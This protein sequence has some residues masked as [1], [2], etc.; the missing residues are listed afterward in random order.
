MKRSENL[1]FAATCG[2]GV[3]AMLAEEIAA[4][5]GQNP[6]RGQGVVS[7]CGPL[8]S[9]YM[10][11]LWSRLASRV[12]LELRTFNFDDGESL[13]REVGEI[14]WADHL[15]L[16]TTFAVDCTVTGD[17]V[18]AIHSR[19]AA[20][21]VKDAIVD[22]FRQ[23]SGRR[24]SVDPVQPGVRLHL[25]V[26]REHATLS[27]DLSGDSLHR[28]GYRVESSIAPLK[29]NLAAA[30]IQASGWL[31]PTGAATTL[32]DP[33][34]GS[35][36]L[37]IEAALAYGDSAPGLFRK[38]FGFLAW[39]GHD[40]SLWQELV[41]EALARETEG[42][43]RKEWPLLVGYDSDPQA[44]RAAR[45]NVKRAGL[46]DRIRI[47]RAELAEL[48]REE[49][50]GCIVTNLPFGERLSA[51][52]EV[53]WL[54]RALGRVARQRFVGWRLA[55]FLSNPV[56]TDSF[57]LKWQ[58]KVRLY[59]GPLQCR[60]LVTTVTDAAEPPFRWQPVAPGPEGESDFA[61]RLRKNLKK[62]LKWA[63][64]E[65]IRCFRV[66]DRDLPEYNLSIDL[67][68][69]WVHV[70]EYAPPASVDGKKA[71]SRLQ[72]VVQCIK[73]ILAVRSDRLFI[74][75]RER[76]R[77]R[78]QYQ[79]RSSQMKLL[80]VREGCCFYLVNFTDY[81]DTGVFLDHRPI[82]Q[83]IFREIQGK[84]FLN[85]FGYTGTATVQAAA[86][87]ALA[88]TT[89]DLSATYCRWL[90]MNLALNGFALQK[91]RVVSADCLQWLGEDTGGY[92]VIF[93]DP[94]TFSNT[95]KERRVFDIQ[96]DHQ[97]LLDLAMARLAVG[98][99]LV[100]STNFRKFVLEPQLAE[101]Y[102]VTEI[103]ASTIAYDF[104][105]NRKIHRCWEIRH[106]TT[107]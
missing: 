49:N 41:D 20:L 107:D 79:R 58:E 102:R 85:L 87:G 54:Y 56:L 26:H 7:W 21:K 50:E 19:F 74:K 38:Y 57:Q 97:T 46:D 48:R 32:V 73:E 103:T 83:R 45:A 47:E 105:R 10:A 94:P 18:V 25:L 4:L 66:Y 95:R 22:Q 101:S 23:R 2:A 27:L 34:C 62:M 61:N 91:N 13:Y 64:R 100:F 82:R 12:F 71:A 55:V 106:V 96:R 93:I 42:A 11:C 24:P 6:Q 44:V 14:G 37:L 43:A 90:K 76:Q 72:H 30:I 51:T 52:E 63:T 98:G 78:Q 104:S 39:Q 81:I 3:E 70:Q 40:R 36:T 75:T 86:G 1:Q 59:N 29:E 17:A 15:S 80:E 92:D 69:K 99:V 60:L 53:A 67:Y 9:G 84:R 31:G 68:E 77:G 88:T 8:R 35:A 16:T 89:V 5:G 65:D 28:R 33:M